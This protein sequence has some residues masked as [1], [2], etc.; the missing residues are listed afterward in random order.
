M[1]APKYIV[2]A[3]PHIRTEENVT[4]IMRD[5]LISLAPAF[6]AGVYFFGVRAIQTVFV[7]VVFALLSE[8]VSRKVMR[9]EN[10][11]SDL[12]AAVTGVLFAFVVPPGLP[13]W[14]TAAGASVSIVLG[15]QIFGGLGYN[16][17]NPALVGR[18][19]LLASWP[20]Y[21]TTW[22]KPFEN[23]T[24]A[25]PLAIL[26]MKLE[27]P[28]PGY[29]DMF[30]GNHAG[31]L[32]ETSALALL[33]GA[34]Y[35]LYRKQITLFIPLSFIGAVMALSAVFGRD[36]LFE[37]LSGGIMLGAFFMATD[38]VTSPITPPGQLVFGIGC[39]L[40][41]VLIRAQGGFPEGVCYAILIMNMLTP[42]ID[43]FVQPRKFGKKK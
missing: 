25:T 13:W 8:Y 24:G 18:A 30:L 14:V 7:S 34:A 35:L 10:T 5:V 43:K 9:R 29:W 38:Y 16:T 4:V 15:K 37:I 11:L 42:L 32:G 21:M 17:F 6:A 39:G 22:L 36:P 3:S 33:I 27:A 2:S 19:V 23:V 31:S 20:V 26:K 40:M 12:S 1:D 28:L 41:T